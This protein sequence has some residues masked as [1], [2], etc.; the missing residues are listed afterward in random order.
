MQKV[1]FFCG[2]PA[3]KSE[4]YSPNQN[5][6]Q[7]ALELEILSLCTYKHTYTLVRLNRLGDFLGNIFFQKYTTTLEISAFYTMKS[8]VGLGSKN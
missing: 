1:F 5:W 8:V 4:G 7:S 6:M 2:S 3:A